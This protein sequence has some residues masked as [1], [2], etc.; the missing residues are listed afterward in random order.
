[1]AHHFIV[2]EADDPKPMGLQP[3]STCCVVIGL[4]GVAMGVAIDFNADPGCGAVEVGNESPEKGV[5]A[6]DVYTELVISD[7]LP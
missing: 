3:F 6:A 4:V 5:L 2:G 7:L 1:M